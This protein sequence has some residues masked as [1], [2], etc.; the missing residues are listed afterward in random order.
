MEETV[1]QKAECPVKKIKTRAQREP[2]ET[3]EEEV[4]EKGPTRMDVDPVQ[5]PKLII[6]DLSPVREP[7]PTKDK[8]PP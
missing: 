3:L 8:E 1:P 5:K 7:S 2:Q 4:E 6:K